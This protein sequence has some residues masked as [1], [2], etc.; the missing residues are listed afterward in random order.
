MP[1]FASTAGL[2]TTTGYL[3]YIDATLDVYGS[4][5][6][7]GRGQPTPDIHFDLGAGKTIYGLIEARGAITPT[8]AAVITCSLGGVGA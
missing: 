6:A 4:D 5:G 7:M 1:V 8:S 2:A 3:G